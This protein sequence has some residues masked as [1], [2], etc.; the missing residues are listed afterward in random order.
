MSARHAAQGRLGL[1]KHRAVHRALTDA[2][3][4]GLL[5]QLNAVC[6]GAPAQVLVPRRATPEPRTVH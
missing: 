1:L 3:C 2:S 5:F 4:S 6:A